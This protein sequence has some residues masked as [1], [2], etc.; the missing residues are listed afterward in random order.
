MPWHLLSEGEIGKEKKN[1]GWTELQEY[2][3]KLSK[4]K[5]IAIS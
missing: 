4:L 2:H 1:E 3:T 5:D